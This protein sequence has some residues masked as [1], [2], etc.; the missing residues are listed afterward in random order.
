MA[1]LTQEAERRITELLLAEGLADT[2]LVLSVKKEED[3]P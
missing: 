2:N 1:Q 3:A